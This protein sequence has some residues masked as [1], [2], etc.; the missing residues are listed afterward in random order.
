MGTKQLELLLYAAATLVAI[1]G[2][3][4]HVTAD[5]R[6]APERFPSI[7]S[8]LNLQ[9]GQDVD[10]RRFLSNGEETDHLASPTLLVALGD[11]TTCS[12][13]QFRPG[14][15]SSRF[16]SVIV[17]YVPKAGYDPPVRDLDPRRYQVF[18]DNSGR[19][20]ERLNVTQAP[21]YYELS[22]ALRVRRA[23]GHNPRAEG[24]LR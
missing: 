11:C 1:T 2:I 3:V 6:H 16:G 13:H 14:S 18:V 19:L 8:S 4:W 5:P 10:V 9:D 20:H 24:F 17:A 21:R 12:A 23:S 7:V 22:P 15:E